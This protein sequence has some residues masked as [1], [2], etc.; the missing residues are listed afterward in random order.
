MP[1]ITRSKSVK[2]DEYKP[3]HKLANDEYYRLLAF[4]KWSSEIY[5]NGNN[6]MDIDINNEIHDKDCELLPFELN[7]EQKGFPNINSAVYPTY[8]QVRSKLETEWRNRYAQTYGRKFGYLCKYGLKALQLSENELEKIQSFYKDILSQFTQDAATAPLTQ[9]TIEAAGI[10]QP[11]AITASTD[12][13]IPQRPSTTPTPIKDENTHPKIATLR[14]KKELARFKTRNFDLENENARLKSEM[15]R[16]RRTC[17]NPFDP[18]EI[19][20]L[21]YQVELAH[22]ISRLEV[23]FNPEGPGMKADHISREFHTLFQRVQDTCT[24][25]VRES[26]ADFQSDFEASDVINSWSL[27]TF[28]SGLNAWLQTQTG[29]SMTTENLLVGVVGA[30]VIDLAFQPTFPRI[31]SGGS[32]IAS[33]YREIFLQ[34]GGPTS[35]RKADFLMFFKLI[36]PRKKDIMNDCA[37]DIAYRIAEEGLLQY[38]RPHQH[39]ESEDLAQN[40]DEAIEKSV[41][42][43]KIMSMLTMALKLKFALT[44]SMSRLRFIYFNPNEHYHDMYMTRCIG[45]DHD[46]ST[47]KACMFPALFLEPR[48]DE[49]DE[50]GG[51]YFLQYNADYNTYFTELVGEISPSALVAKAMV[52]T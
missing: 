10:P 39:Q 15:D 7:F 50:P 11:A 31:L 12:L 17:S 19:R 44:E 34:W 6:G 23:G 5:I 40:D 21:R 47:I 2:V 48:R 3:K 41:K 8:K 24:G 33:I 46:T 9:E 13:A 37:K 29:G 26:N 20:G 36:G 43:S 4:V 52:L 22:C 51:D 28:K 45:S 18:E 38:F 32:T 14:L 35:L 1:P 30:A 27:K 16:L 49:A 42:D 25:V